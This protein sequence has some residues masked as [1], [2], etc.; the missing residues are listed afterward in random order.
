MRA[1][2]APV[3][4]AATATRAPPG[5]SNGG[6]RID[7]PSTTM[8]SAVTSMSATVTKTVHMAGMPAA[9]GGWAIIPP[10]SR[11]PTEATW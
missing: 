9:S 2:I 4:S 5:M 3:G 11:S 6:W 7:P 1:N 8:R 10:T